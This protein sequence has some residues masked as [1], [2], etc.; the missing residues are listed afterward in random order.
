MT[1]LGEGRTLIR[2]LIQILRGFRALEEDASWFKE[3][4][5]V[6]GAYFLY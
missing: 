2:S 5:R 6:L 1:E 4:E 3:E